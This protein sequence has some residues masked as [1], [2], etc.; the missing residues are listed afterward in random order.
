M[1]KVILT[2]GQVA[3][4]DD[5]D[6]ERVNEHKWHAK[7]CKETQSFYA[8]TNI[9]TDDGRQRTVE[10]QR[11]IMREP[12]GVV[13]DHSNGDSLDC[14]KGSLRLATSVESARNRGKY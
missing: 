2:Q 14:R 7:W 10:L 1:A 9:R 5:D 13:V 6:L 3:I 8:R 11:F 12:K 4:D